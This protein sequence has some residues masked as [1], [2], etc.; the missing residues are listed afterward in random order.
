MKTISLLKR[1]AFPLN[2]NAVPGE[3]VDEF[4][5]SCMKYYSIKKSDVI[6]KI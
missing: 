1:R 5:L 3:T 4:V 2:R 6:T